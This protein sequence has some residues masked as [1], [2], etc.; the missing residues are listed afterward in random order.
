M[1]APKNGFF[2][3]LDRA[4]G[5]L[6]SAEKFAYANWA[7]H[8]DPDSGRPVET[9]LAEY[10]PDRDAYV[11]PS[12][13]G[14]HNWHP[15]AFNPNTGLVYIPARDIGWVMTE[16]GDKIFTYGVDNLD[17]LIGAQTIPPVSGNLLAWDPI[18]Q[19]K[20]W[21]RP[22]ELI[23]N[24]G[25]LTTASNLVFFGTA[26]GT[27]NALD[28]ATGEV[29]LSIEVGTGILAPPITYAIDNTQ[30]VA[31]LA[32]YGGPAAATMQGGEAALRYENNGRLLVF[33]LD[34]DPVP[35][36]NTKPKR[37]PVPKPPV[38]SADSA[39]LE[40]GRLLYFYN[41]GGCHGAYGS[42]PLLPDLRYL[43]KDKHAQFKEIVLGGLLEANGMAS[44][45]AILSEDDVAAIHAYLISQQ[46]LAYAAQ[47]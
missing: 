38:L 28:A 26:E 45:A 15:M 36:P 16:R 44:F 17:E 39:T 43:S 47:Q 35:L 41:C 6:I 40:T 8:I 42:T 11:F 20:V 2:Y 13:A 30:Y 34:G 19:K 23:W 37:G 25:V 7:S 5:E 9:G 46:H 12:P 24:G 21:E 4:T 10:G 29:F 27:F 1:Q 33:K 22:S 14:A 32:G 31:V 18:A 3:V